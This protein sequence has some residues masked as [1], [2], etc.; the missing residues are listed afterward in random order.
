MIPWREL[1]FGRGFTAMHFGRYFFL[2]LLPFPQVRRLGAWIISRWVKTKSQD[3]A[4]VAADPAISAAAKRLQQ[5]GF[6]A[7]APV[8]TSTQVDDIIQYLSAE[9]A[10]DGDRELFV[11][12]DTKDALR[13]QYRLDT[14]MRCPH[15]LEAI[16]NPVVLNIAQ[17]FLGCKP[18]ISAIGL[19][20]SFP[21]AAKPADV[22]TFHRDSEAW[23]LLNM[24]VYLTD[25]DEGGGPHRYVFG[26][27]RTRGKLRL[28]PY[29]DEYVFERYGKENVHTILGPRGTTFVENGWG[30][31]EGHPPT[32]QR[33]LMLAVM[34]SVG[35]IPVYDYPKV[36]VSRPHNYDRY[37]NR[38][39]VAG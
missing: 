8:L 37:V 5:Q 16:N 36:R 26:S 39:L 14:I 24:F 18:T 6:T 20:W 29:S 32:T 30:I 38:L 17:Q 35:P 22:Q 21:S 3:P 12:P 13:A 23:R 33:R 34:Y 28:T 19:H 10:H 15:V 31:H 9:P 1:S 11:T 7:L 4:T 2:R 27:H 25:V